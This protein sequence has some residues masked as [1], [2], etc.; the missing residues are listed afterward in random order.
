MLGT[1]NRWCA[2]AVAVIALA[3][4][5]LAIASDPAAHQP[6]PRIATSASISLQ[7]PTT[8]TLSVRGQVSFDAAGRGPGNQMLYSAPNLATALVAVLMHGAIVDAARTAQK[9]QLQEAADRVLSRYR[10]APAT[11][12]HTDLLLGVIA[13]QTSLN[14]TRRLALSGSPQGDWVIESTPV[15]TMVQDE[16]ALILDN[17]V[18][19]YDANSPKAERFEGVVRVIASP[20][21]RPGDAGDHWNADEGRRL[22]NTVGKLYAHS[23]EVLLAHTARTDDAVVADR[24]LRYHEGSNEKF[25]RGKLLW[26]N[27]GRAVFKNLH[28]WIMSVP[29]ARRAGDPEHASNCVDPLSVED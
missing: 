14:P 3:T 29:L 24:T 9:R 19:V 11:I 13:Q 18:V 7:G 15:M 5:A 28:G 27:C 22:R 26:Q 23:F 4:H 16:R 2:W 10:D 21:R 25:E 1:P 20:L 12:R 6:F 17:S 8:E